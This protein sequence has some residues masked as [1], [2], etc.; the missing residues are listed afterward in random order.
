MPRSRPGAIRAAQPTRP[1]WH[2]RPPA[3]IPGLSLATSLEILRAEK[4]SA[5]PGVFT[6]MTAA[7]LRQYQAFARPPGH[8]PRYPQEAEC[9]CPGCSLDD[10]RYAREVLDHVVRSLPPRARAELRG[11]I[12]ALDK[13]FLRCTLPD[14]FADNE[15][16]WHRRLMA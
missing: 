5:L 13:A 11:R 9:S 6:G 10:V 3:R 12:L 7:A 1:A 14:P 15:C 4:R 16:W 8:G 2:F